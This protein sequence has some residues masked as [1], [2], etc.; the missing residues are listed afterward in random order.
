MDGP[1][2]DFRQDTQIFSHVQDDQTGSGAH[3]AAYS[4]GKSDQAA[5]LTITPSSKEMKNE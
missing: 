3:P 4:V 5:N 1:Q 2:F